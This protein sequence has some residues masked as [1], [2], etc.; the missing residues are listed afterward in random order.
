MFDNVAEMI[1]L[2]GMGTKVAAPARD[3]LNTLVAKLSPPWKS[4]SNYFKYFMQELPNMWRGRQ[5]F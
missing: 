3:K 2:S 1:S 5:A 4:A